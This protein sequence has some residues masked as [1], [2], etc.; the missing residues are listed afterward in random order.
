M[1]GRYVT[2]ASIPPRCHSFHLF[3][4][5][6][7]CAFD[8]WIEYVNHIMKDRNSCHHAF[9]STLHFSKHI[10]AL[11]HVDMVYSEEFGVGL[12]TPMEA[13]GWWSCKL[14]HLMLLQLA[15]WCGCICTSQLCVLL[16]N[17]KNDILCLVE[18]FEELIPDVRSMTVV[19]PFTGTDINI[20]DQ[21]VSAPSNMC[22]ERWSLIDSHCDVVW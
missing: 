10:K 6:C 13:R 16:G 20:G 2:Y 12:D 3:R 19:N 7:N 8:R 11:L 5:G 22:S 15:H 1:N 21:R 4:Q 17:Y 18:W 9:E 14:L